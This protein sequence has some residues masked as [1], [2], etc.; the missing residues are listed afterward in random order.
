MFGEMYIE[1]ELNISSFLFEPFLFH[2]LFLVFYLYKTINKKIDKWYYFLFMP[3]IFHNLLLN[4]DGLSLPESSI[5]IYKYTFYLLEF[6]MVIYAFRILEKHSKAIE[7]FYSVLEKKSLQWLQVLFILI[8]VFHSLI[9]ISDAF[10][11][12]AGDWTVVEIIVLYLLAGIALFIPYWIGYNGFLQP[13]I[14]RERLFLTTNKVD[15]CEP[16]DLEKNVKNDEKESAIIIEDIQKFKEVKKRIEKK[17]LYTDPKLNLHSLA[18]SL[19]LNEKE[20]S[21]LINECGNVNFYRFINDFR[22]EKFKE[23]LQSPE[24][25]QFSILGL[26][27]EAGFSSKSTFYKVF[28][29]VE[30]ITPKQYQDTLNKSE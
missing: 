21:R 7:G 28:K 16:F 2:L 4:F 27:T 1:E 11:L 9:I 22:V 10:E 12:I 20:L 6:G 19:D 17:E 5:S 8:I 3:G 24:A 13:E 30:G 26:A 23:L 15:N 14:F 29:E 25:Q 18:K